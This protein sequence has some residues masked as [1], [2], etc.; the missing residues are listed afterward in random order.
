VGTGAGYDAGVMSEAGIPTAMLFVRNESGISHSPV[1]FATVSDC[2]AGVIAL[3]ETV[4]LLSTSV[5]SRHLG[6]A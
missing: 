6:L 3:T 2:E 4:R 5:G 1:E